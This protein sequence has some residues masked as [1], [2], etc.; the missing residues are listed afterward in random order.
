MTYS[1][2]PIRDASGSVG[3]KLIACHDVAAELAAERDRDAIAA[4]LTNVLD[5]HYRRHSCN[6]QAMA[7]HQCK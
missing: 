4:S 6:G 5:K 1:C 3:G 2:S 7:L